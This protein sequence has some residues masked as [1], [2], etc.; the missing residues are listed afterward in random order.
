MK[1][2]LIYNISIVIVILLLLLL[3]L[4]LSFHYLLLILCKT[5]VKKGDINFVNNDK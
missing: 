3:I 2:C 1:K 5:L 4:I